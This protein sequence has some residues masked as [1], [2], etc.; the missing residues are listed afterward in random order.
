MTKIEEDVTKVIQWSQNIEKPNVKE[1]LANWKINKEKFIR[2]LFAGELIY[3]VPEKLTFELGENSK[4]EKFESFKDHVYDLCENFNLDKYLCFIKYE[5]FFKNALERDIDLPNGK[6]IKK[7]TKFLRTLRFFIDD[8]K[9]LADVQN[10]AS[11]IIQENKIEGY[12]CL[13]VHPLDFLSSS[14]NTLNWRSCH[15]L[16][17]EYR[18]GNLSYMQD[19]CT[20]MAY[21]RT[22]KDVKLPNFPEEVPWNNKKWRCLLF[23]N[24]SNNLIFA[25]RQYPFS[26]KSILDRVN[27]ELQKLMSYTKWTKWRNDYIEK[28]ES[29]NDKEIIFFNDAEYMPINSDIYE[30]SKLVK[31]A[32]NSRHFNDLIHSCCYTHPYYMYKKE[33]PFFNKSTMTNLTVGS[34]VKCL[35]CGEKII[36]GTDSMMCHECECKYGNSDSD[37]YRSCD[38]CG[39]RIWYNDWVWV[40]G[41]VVCPNC[42][43]TET[44][45]CEE[46]GERYFNSARKYNKVK[47]KFVCNDCYNEEEM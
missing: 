40:D 9:L 21:L 23:F 33:N 14:E 19:Q 43:E 44:F 41:C 26:A 47:E 25:G 29:P 13:S 17:G 32:K 39:Q 34:A 24:E 2:G 1:L 8:E 42:A 46:C 18:A 16:D 12:L 36:D 22:D 5:E 7:G 3:Q 15:S 6:K 37:D 38:C 45:V 35:W 10:Y 11:E 31:D 28:Y 27:V 30:K 4:K 20:I